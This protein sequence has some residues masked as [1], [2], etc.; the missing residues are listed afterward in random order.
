MK[1]LREG[2]P[3]EPGEALVIP[4]ARQVHSFG[5]RSPIDV[6]FCDQNWDV[7]HVVRVLQPNRITKW[8]WGSY[9]VI[10]LQAGAAGDVARADRVDYSLSDR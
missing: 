8:V 3:L 9:Y 5:M 10:E 6:I 4:R 7:R 1:G 2:P